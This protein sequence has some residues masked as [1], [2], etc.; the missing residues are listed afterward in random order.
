MQTTSETYKRLLA[1]PHTME[2]KA[3]IAGV[4]YYGGQL[5]SVSTSGALYQE[6][7]VGNAAARRINMEILPQGEIPKRAEIR[8]FVRLTDG[9]AAS[10]W[11]PKGVYYFANRLLDWQTGVMTV[12]G[13]DAMLKADMTWLDGS[14]DEVSWPMPA[15][16]AVADIAARMGVE[17]DG[18]T[19][20][21]PR[22]AVQYPADGEGDLTAREVL[23]RIAAANAGN[24]IMTDEG[25]L[26]LV[27]LVSMPPETSYL[28]DGG[29]DAITFSGTRIEV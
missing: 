22:F 23:Q 19:Q 10:E 25:R 11:L 4:T 27:P 6:L 3:E 7:S 20:L 21:D 12:L 29:G 24:W 14:Y 1:R 8:L 17:V 18:R 5:V 28:V 13:Y 15:A 16:D 26:R 2:V 9:T